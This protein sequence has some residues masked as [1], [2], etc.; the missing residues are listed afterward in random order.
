MTRVTGWN[1][2]AATLAVLALLAACAPVAKDLAEDQGDT[3]AA[4]G[5]AAEVISGESL[6]S[7]I[8]ELGDDR[9]EGR[10]PGSAG[11]RLTQDYLIAQMGE[12]GFQPA[13]EDGGWLQPFDIVGVNATAPAT[14]EFETEGGT[15]SLDWWDEYIAASGVQEESAEISNAELVFV[16]YGIEAPEYDWD[17]FKGHDVTGKV[18]VVMNNDPDWDPELFEGKARLYYG[19]PLPQWNQRDRVL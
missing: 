13:G 7:V 19:T 18:L 9:Y 12:I 8:A 15:V 4:A 10:G 5:P 11:D 3:M 16:G 2:A 17:D 1:G 6:R 14:W